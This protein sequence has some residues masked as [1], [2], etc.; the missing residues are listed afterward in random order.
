MNTPP[1]FESG[2]QYQPKAPGSNVPRIL[3][4]IFLAVCVPCLI[5]MF[6]LVRMGFDFMKKGMGIVGC[7]T[8]MTYARDAMVD[9]AKDHNGNLPPAKAWQDEIY[10][11][12][13]KLMVDVTKELKD[14][15]DFMKGALDEVDVLKD[16]KGQFGCLTG[17]DEKRTAFV[18][19]E[20][21]AGK[22]LAEVEKDAE[23]IWIFEAD[24][25]GP[26]QVGKYEKQDDKTSP[27]IMDKVRGWFTIKGKDTPYLKDYPFS[28]GNLKA[29]IEKAKAEKREPNINVKVG[30]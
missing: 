5:V 15:P 4:I 13:K 25:T 19:N 1:T 12:Y 28:Q 9:Y 11:Y 30:N 24:R 14:S 2:P 29:E 18:Y 17:T 7:S 21:I 20:A 23:I 10:P 27:K 22:S 6:F 26:N 3:L 8:S 16:P